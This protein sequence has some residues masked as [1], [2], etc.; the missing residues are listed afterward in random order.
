MKLIAELSLNRNKAKKA[1]KD[2]EETLTDL[3]D[4][5]PNL[6]PKR[7]TE[8]SISDKMRFSEDLINFVEV[9]DQY[10]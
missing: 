5:H 9:I 1:L 7:P 3:Y 2:L 10:K 4:A 8:M 6:F